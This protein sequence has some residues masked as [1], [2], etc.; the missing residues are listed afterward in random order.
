MEQD[1]KKPSQAQGGALVVGDG[2]NDGDSQTRYEQEHNRPVKHSDDN[3]Q[4]QGQ[5]H[6][7]AHSS[8]ANKIA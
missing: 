1:G 6:Q 2:Q 7:D 8:G 5:Q 3:S 4:Q